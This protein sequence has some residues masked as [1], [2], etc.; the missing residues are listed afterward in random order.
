MATRIA[1]S[2]MC[3]DQLHIADELERLDAAGIDLLHCD[4][5]DGQYVNNLAI[6]PE[7]LLAV[8][9]AT[10]IALDIH[11]AAVDPLKYIE[12]FAKIKPE[13]ISF[14][15][16][17]CED[18]SAV[19]Q[20]IRSYHIKPAIALN[21]E[22]P[23]EAILPYLNDVEMVLMMTVNPGFAGQAFQRSVLEKLR[24]LRA[25]L[26]DNAYAPL[27]EVDGNINATTIGEMSDCLPDI[28]VLG[29]SALFHKK[30]NKTYAERCVQ[31]WSEV[32]R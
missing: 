8:K 22:T 15:V 24:T 23:L 12:M 10:N 16:E 4:V 20:K 30:D 9:E 18:V 21:P 26:A 5:M 13:Y 6:G 3:A 2:I 25:T 19:I 29:T 17:V 1:A 14:H 32:K 27:I 28:F 31:I 11:L 7:W